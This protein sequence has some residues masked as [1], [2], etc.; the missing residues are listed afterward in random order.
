MN[1]RSLQSEWMPWASQPDSSGEEIT[2]DSSLTDQSRVNDR[3]NAIPKSAGF[4]TTVKSSMV[5]R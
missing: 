5:R 4:A 1:E 3:I 2:E